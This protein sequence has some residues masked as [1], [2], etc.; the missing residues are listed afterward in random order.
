MIGME[1]GQ[2]PGGVQSV[3]IV[4]MVSWGVG[5]VL[6]VVRSAIP[7]NLH[8]SPGKKRDL[9]TALTC[10]SIA[11]LAV[12]TE[13]TGLPKGIRAVMRRGN[14]RGRH[15]GRGSRADS[16]RRRWRRHHIGL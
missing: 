11:G 12:G 9:R 6:V 4:R 7:F 14:V 8:G 5:V 10:D 13:R 16:F 15:S 2:V 3:S 1:T